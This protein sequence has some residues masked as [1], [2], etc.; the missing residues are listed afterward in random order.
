ME[1]GFKKPNDFGMEADKIDKIKERAAG[2]DAKTTDYINAKS[3][4]SSDK[5]HS[6]L[7][8]ATKFCTSCGARAASNLK[9]CPRCGKPFGAARSTVNVKESDEKP[10]PPTNTAGIHNSTQ[11]SKSG[12]AFSHDEAAEKTYK[13]PILSSK[14]VKIAAV[15]LVAAVIGGIGSLIADNPTDPDLPESVVTS[16]PE[17]TVAVVKTT[18]IPT[19]EPTVIPTVKPTVT[20]TAV[21]AVERVRTIFSQSNGNTLSETTFTEDLNNDGI[22]ETIILTTKEAKY[23][24]CYVN[25]AISNGTAYSSY[26][27]HEGHSVEGVYL[28]DLDT[29]DS[30]KEIAVVMLCDSDDPMLGIFRYGKNGSGLIQFYQ[31]DE[32]YTGVI[33]YICVSMA[34]SP[35]ISINDDRT[36]T[37]LTRTTSRGMWEIYTYYKID[38]SGY[39]VE[40]P[41]EV[42]EVANIGYDGGYTSV[43]KTITGRGIDLY[44]GD[45][46]TILQDDGNNHILIQKST[47]ES[48]WFTMYGYDVN[49]DY[50]LSE[51][52]DLFLM[53]D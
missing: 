53:V 11:D 2:T 20:P 13:N 3:E 44:A 47:G 46:I 19:A 24:E 29:T 43:K 32:Y 36:F 31:N 35:P 40:I 49:D 14:A 17:A 23:E 28:L 7:K 27:M 15:V 48:G 42:Y 16:K 22:A 9:F 34:E 45:K 50:R 5:I 26:D 33:D 8:K 30:A 37:L 6:E 39:I 10:T 25:I 18:V 41:Q 21:P 51:V 12:D 38:S 4:D 52:S 1:N